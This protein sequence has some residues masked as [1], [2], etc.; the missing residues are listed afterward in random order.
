MS[1]I[2]PAASVLLARTP[3]S[4]EVFLVDRSPRLR[5]MGGLTAFP[6]GKCDDADERLARPADGLTT[7]H[8]A[9]VRELFEETGVLLAVSPAE[10]SPPVGDGLRREVVEGR[11]PFAELLDRLSLRLSPDLLRPAGALTTPAFA[12]VRFHTAF[13]VAE[14]PAG[15]EATVWPGELVAGLWAS[16][17]G[18]LA[19]W[20]AGEALLS[21]PT[22]SILEVL[23]GRPI[24]ELPR[25]L[26]PLLASLDGGRLPPIWFS[27]GVQMLPMDCRGLPPTTHTNA[28]LVGTGP[29][30]LIDPG[31]ED[32]EE[33][34][35]LFD[36]L[37]APPTAIILTHHHP[38]HVGAAAAA[39]ARY[40]APVL[41]HRLT[42]ELLAGEVRVDRLIGA[43]DSFDLGP[44][45]H[46]RGR[47]AM[48]ALLTPGHAPG[49]LAF[50]EPDYRLLFAADMVSTI[51]S[52]IICPDDGDLGEYLASLGRL[53]GLPA[54][55]LLPG[56]GPPSSRP[57][58]VLEEAVKHREAR[59]A[60][61]VEALAGGPHTVGELAL[62]LYR[63]SPPAVLRLAEMQVVSGLRKLAREGRARE[64]DQGW[65]VR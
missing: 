37:A 1:I 6:G 56:H 40:R 33:Q 57:G 19:S 39:R 36:A 8:V 38:D 63:G 25:R 47:W 52:V 16:A 23:T 12:Q 14:L 13:F 43:G 44:A 61:L 26:A 18:A 21:P 35:R 62:A 45:P 54:R 34:Q 48:A 9:A 7:A 29:H 11:L 28:Y 64:C 53:R 46:G 65:Q 4:D 17:S 22:V 20:R 31:P 2:T 58:H 15:Q 24:D 60:Q 32:A 3:G 10:A 42:A 51:S 5:F 59:E 55:L 30:Y 41:A 50:W 27:P 49:H